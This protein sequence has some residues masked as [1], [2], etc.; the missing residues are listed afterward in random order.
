MGELGVDVVPVAC[1][2]R[3]GVVGEGVEVD[4]DIPADHVGKLRCNT[5]LGSSLVVLGFLVELEIM[6]WVVVWGWME[7]GW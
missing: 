7:C 2:R 3:G 4:N 1:R 6:S 5:F